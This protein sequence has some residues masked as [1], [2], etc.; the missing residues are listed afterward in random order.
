M[1]AYFFF[2]QEMRP[3]VMAEDS[4][5][6]YFTAAT[7][8]SELWKDVDEKS[9]EEYEEKARVDKE[10]YLKEKAEYEGSAAG[11]SKAIKAERD[12]NAPKRNM[13][14]YF[15]FAQEMRPKVMAEDSTLTY[16][17]A[18]TKISELWKDVDEKTKE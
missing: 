11:S 12:E 3:K 15:F 13:S 9:K 17:T 6:T 7:K 4:T 16:F 10:R 18:A 14:A 2:A 1:S 8:I 5:L